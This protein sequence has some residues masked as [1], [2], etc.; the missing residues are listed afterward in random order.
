M[1]LKKIK[2]SIE[3]KSLYNV[4][5]MLEDEIIDLKKSADFHNKKY[6]LYCRMLENKTC[7]FDSIINEIMTLKSGDKGRVLVKG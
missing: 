5:N 4:L 6:L 7:T 3:I 1:K 2:K